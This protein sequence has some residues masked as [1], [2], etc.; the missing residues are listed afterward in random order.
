[1]NEPAVRVGHGRILIGVILFQFEAP[2][3][4]DRTP[5]TLRGY[6]LPEKVDLKPLKLIELV[7]GD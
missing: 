2:A 1:L 4:F 3:R 5:A 7:R 6:S